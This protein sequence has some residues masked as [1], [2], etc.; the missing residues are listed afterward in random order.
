MRRAALLHELSFV[1]SLGEYKSQQSEPVQTSTRIRQTGDSRVPLSDDEKALLERWSLQEKL[2]DQAIAGYIQFRWAIEL[3][4][5]KHAE[6]FLFWTERPRSL[7]DAMRWIRRDV[8]DALP[9]LAAVRGALAD[10]G[11]ELARWR[12]VPGEGKAPLLNPFAV[13][14]ALSLEHAR[15]VYGTVTPLQLQ[16]VP[17]LAGGTFF[18]GLAYGHLWDLYGD[19]IPSDLVDGLGLKTTRPGHGRIGQYQMQDSQWWVLVHIG[20]VKLMEVAR[21][22]NISYQEIQ[23]SLKNTDRALGLQKL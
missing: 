4:A 1:Y 3:V 19:G 17:N 13:G 9:D 15:R 5:R 12:L 6:T 23:R 16:V 7:Q 20:G 11:K 8:V 18:Q 14:L 21:A 10:L 2:L 22:A